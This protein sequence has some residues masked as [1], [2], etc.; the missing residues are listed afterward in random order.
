M[1][2]I[3]LAAFLIPFLVLLF[4]FRLV[5]FDEDF[6]KSEFEKYKI[7]DLFD[8]EVAGNAI[9]NLIGYMKYGAP[10][11]DFFNEKEKAHMADV[12][13]II[14]KLLLLFYILCFVVLAVL[15]FNRKT[16]F[17]SLL[18]GGV[19]TLIFLLLFFISSYAFFDFIFHKFHEVS[20]SND[21]WMLNPE[22]DNLKALL[23]DGFFFDALMRIFFIS[24]I[25]SITLI[26]FGFYGKKVLNM[27]KYRYLR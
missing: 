15:L 2:R 8:K 3:P 20:F 17:N 7:Y 24:S 14:Q 5:V 10:L 6:Y 22:I 4:S 11:S 1:R 25:S 26:F 21:F 13:G 18:Y 19:F 27:L 12:R 23:P 16:F 9:N